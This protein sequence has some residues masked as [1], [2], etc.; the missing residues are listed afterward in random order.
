[1]RRIFLLILCLCLLT[2]AVHATDS[3]TNMDSNAVV[4]ENGTCQMTLTFQITVTGSAED[5]Y[6]PLPGSAKDISLN[7]N[8]AKT[9]RRDG[10]RWVDLS[11]VVYGAGTFSLTLHYSLPDLVSK[12]GKSGLQLELP[13]L[14][15]FSYPVERMTFSIILPGKPESRPVFSSIY[16]PESMDAYVEYTISDSMISGSFK[17]VLKDHETLSM[18]LSVTEEMFPQNLVKQW[19]LSYDDLLQYAFLLLAIVYWVFFLRS[20]LPRRLRR[21]QAPDGVTAGELGCCLSGLG[22]DFPLMILSWAKL[23]YLNIQLDRYQRVLLHKNMDMGNERSSF[24]MNCFKSL[25]GR[26]M[27][28][29][30]GSEHFARLSRK[31]R[32][33]IPGAAHYFN[34]KSGNM[35]I[36]RCLTAAIG[37]VAGYTLAIAF[38]YD[39][40][41]QVLLSVVLIPLGGILSW[42][43][44]D[45]LRGLL[46]RHR[47]E[48]VFGIFATLAWL[49]LG[50]W[51]GEIGVV[52]FVILTQYLSGF[53][54]MHGGRRTE[55]GLQAR[56]EI[57]GLRKYLRTV[58]A[59]EL[60]GILEHNPDYYFDLL[61]DAIALGVDKIFTRQM[62]DEKL[63]E[64][65]YLSVHGS[66]TTA[67]AWNLHLRQVIRLMDE[68]QRQVKWL[69]F[70]NR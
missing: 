59:E 46:L 63:T 65:P 56:N 27:T 16:H 58:T 34:K 20:P 60:R 28:V 33:A 50:I 57:W 13:L 70:L 41:W 1:M 68:Q 3:V 25:F 36:F 61:P 52:I 44:Q 23:G 39:T 45:S 21:L 17:Q 48:L 53:A 22:V 42:S 54:A 32:K 43:I 29:D 66:T 2:T 11:E 5:L 18:T 30:V 37:A 9:F 51:A 62:K 26:R 55:G 6:F 14:S 4:A 31:V 19:S 49:V 67:K 38:A 10:M 47:M 40:L 7:G 64:C 15:G 35:L 24:E 8:G 12:V 69:R